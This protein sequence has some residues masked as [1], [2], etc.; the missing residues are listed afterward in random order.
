MI[1]VLGCV[2]PISLASDSIDAFGT[3]C[4]VGILFF[5]WAVIESWYVLKKPSRYEPP[6]SIELDEFHEMK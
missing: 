1:I 2:P 6:P 3:I 5:C 4:F